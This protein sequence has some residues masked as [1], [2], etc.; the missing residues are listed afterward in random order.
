VLGCGS[1]I[2]REAAVTVA[3]LERDPAMA[4]I[5]LVRRADPGS[6]L[7]AALARGDTRLLGVATMA[8]EVPG[9]P[10]AYDLAR[11][12]YGVRAIN[13]GG[14]QGIGDARRALIRGAKAYAARYNTLLLRHLSAA[15]A[16]QP[17]L[18]PLIHALVEHEPVAAVMD[19]IV[20]GA[21]VNARDKQGRSTALYYA[22]LRLDRDGAMLPVVK[23]MVERG[24]EV[25]ARCI[26]GCTP[27][28]A[29]CEASSLQVVDYLV[30][31][32]AD[33]NA[34]DDHG[35]TPLH[36]AAGRDPRHPRE[37][38]MAIIRL[39]VARGAD[40]N[41]VDKRGETPRDWA[42]EVAEDPAA[43]TLLGELGGRY[44][45]GRR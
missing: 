26:G 10:H 9:P 16:S 35:V 25:N 11:T 30:S 41:A 29:A 4:E 22:A 32:G 21:D 23:A 39:L 17:A 20:A 14:D 7:A 15:P 12:K 24:A 13:G 33:V 28:Y 37:Q 3:E 19:L 45:R 2:R 43:D 1:S 31:R 8:L 44:G 42:A 34:R 36:A 18:S 6:A 40:V 27:L 38:R 5:V